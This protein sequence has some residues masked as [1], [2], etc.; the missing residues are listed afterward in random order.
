VA[1]P[2]LPDHIYLGVF[3]GHGG[4]GAAIYTEKHLVN[5]IEDTKEW[6]EY[7]ATPAA[8]RDP[9]QI[10]RALEAAFLAIDVKLRHYQENYTPTSDRARDRTDTSGCTATTCMVTPTHFVCANSGDSRTVLGTNGTTIP[11]SEDHKPEDQIE[12]DRITNAGGSVQWKRVDGDLAVSRAFGDFE[13]KKRPDL[14]AE[15]QKVSPFPDVKIVPRT[16]QDD[17]LLLACDGLWDVYSSEEAIEA[18]RTLFAMGES[19]V[20]LVAEEMID[21]SMAK[22][23]RDNISAIVVR[24]SGAS[25]GGG[26]GVRALRQ[27]R[28]EE[29]TATRA[30]NISHDV[31][32]STDYK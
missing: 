20:V 1:M 5:I 9:A 8:A 32:E 29:A 26:G 2:S 4:A 3:D 12:Y 31:A 28:E 25:V 7:V 30:R 19:D 10:G 21:S 11:L 22:G 17:V 15:Q 14:P 27:S 23:S 6:K 24:L 18:V 13:Y 16:P